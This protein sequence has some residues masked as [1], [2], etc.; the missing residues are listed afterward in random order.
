MAGW[1]GFLHSALTWGRSLS[2]GAKI[3][4]GLGLVACLLTAALWTF[5]ARP[6]FVPLYTGLELQDAARIVDQLKAE[7]I[8]FRLGDDGR[9][10][11]VPQD[12][13]HQA[14]LD[15]ATE[16]LPRQGTVGFELLDK[17]P[18]GATESDR[19][20]AYLRALQGEL[21]RTISQ[22][23]GVEQARVHI[24]VPEPQLFASQ[25]KPV[26]AAVLLRLRPG[27]ELEPQQVQGIVHL[28]THGVEGLKAE[29]V[30]V[31]D[32]RGQVLSAQLEMGESSSLG[33][34]DRLLG[35]QW[36]FG[37]E[38][39]RR[40][41]TLLEQVL[42]AGNVVTRVAAE[43]NFDSRTV[44]RQLFEPGPN[45]GISRSVQELRETFSG[46]AGSLP[47]TAGNIPGYQGSGEGGPASYSREEIT[48][49]LEVG[50]V[51]EQLVVMPG[52]VRRLSVAVVVNREL[53]DVQQQAIA[54]V[55]AAAIGSDPARQDRITVTG[56]PFATKWLE[57][58]ELPS[59]APP[60]LVL[61]RE[62]RW[63]AVGAL[64]ALALLLV[65]LGW[66]RRRR[67]AVARLEPVPAPVMAAPPEPP[68]PEPREEPGRRAEEERTRAEVEKVARKSPETVAQLIR[69]WMSEE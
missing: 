61:A 67:R 18:L 4:A 13:V 2:A 25:V 64:A 69:V 26:T 63:I 34:A 41:Q 53:T 5:F 17:P 10:V 27:A 38:L 6:R 68:P 48:R 1:K 32:Q 55:V 50:Q 14:R 22:L 42:G 16:G 20:L 54:E 51:R 7:K 29:D 39:E 9:A 49:N 8:P 35:I 37:R 45:E 60:T 11:L 24:A 31:V 52:S 56:I 3:L 36:E 66:R 65:W 44:D 30:T 59:S 12:R 47:P 19:R 43:L 23:E 40:L 15:L 57:P 33:K 62:W 58:E 46:P 28:V 21:A